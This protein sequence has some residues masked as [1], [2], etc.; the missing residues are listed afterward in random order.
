MPSEKS[1]SFRAQLQGNAQDLIR[2]IGWNCG[3]TTDLIAGIVS[4]LAAYTEEGVPMAPSIFLCSSIS[5]LVQRAG[6]GEFVPLSKPGVPT[7]TAAMQ[8]LKAAAPLCSGHWHIY[9][10]RAADGQTLQFGV[11]SGSSDPSA[12]AV[13]QVVLEGYTP[14]FPLVRI[15]QSGLNK[16]EVRINTGD[17]VEFRFN[18]ERDVARLTGRQDMGDLSNRIASKAGD[19]VVFKQFIERL[20]SDAI[21]RSHGTLI[22]VVPSGMGLPKSFSDVIEIQPPLDLYSRLQEHIAGGRT[23]TSVS[24]LQ[25]AAEL[26]AGFVSSDGITIFNDSGFVLGYRAF[27][28][29]NTDAVLSEG[30]ARSRAF[31][32]M[33]SLVGKELIAAF[34]RSQDGR[35]E[36]IH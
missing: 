36:L 12:L 2:Q 14:E 13:D 1:V 23:A 35:S 21:L 27:V 17:G 19:L 26:I 30:G 5:E 34:F 18:D 4:K 9:V 33:K 28:K 10:E 6:S 7:A 3:P 29:S 16:V 22:A 32:E 15:V 11:F 24:R 8:I 25:T 20:M 31:Q